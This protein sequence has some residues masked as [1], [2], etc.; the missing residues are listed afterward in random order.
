MKRL[1]V[2]HANVGRSQTAIELYRRRG[3]QGD[4]AGTDVDRPGTTLGDRPLAAT[5]VQV[6]YEDYGINMRQNVR[7]QL[8]REQAAPYDE[9][10]VITA[11]ASVPKWLLRDPR[12]IFWD[13]PDAIGRDAAFTRGVVAQVAAYVDKLSL[14]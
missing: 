10:I 5:I 1:F 4:S 6:M 12:V 14:W 13:I 7:T 3:G 8:S 11:K 9:I 2:C